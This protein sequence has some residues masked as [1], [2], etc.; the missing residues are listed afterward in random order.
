[1]CRV[2]ERDPLDANSWRRGHSWSFGQ[3][4]VRRRL[5]GVVLGRW[6]YCI[7]VLYSL[8]SAGHAVRLGAVG[9]QARGGEHHWP[10]EYA[11][12]IEAAWVAAGSGLLDLLRRQPRELG[13]IETAF[14]P[15]VELSRNSARAMWTF[16]VTCQMT[17]NRKSS[18]GQTSDR[19][20]GHVKTRSRG[21]HLRIGKCPLTRRQGVYRGARVSLLAHGGH[22]RHPPAETPATYARGDPPE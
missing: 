5:V 11:P 20:T 21:Q 6:R 16:R 19:R 22:G 7:C 4:T 10:A 12:S 3:V 2:A 18:A 1:M 9:M 13:L 17:T 15:L 14:A 8:D